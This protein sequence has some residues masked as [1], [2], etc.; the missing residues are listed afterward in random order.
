MSPVELTPSALSISLLPSIRGGPVTIGWVAWVC[1]VIPKKSQDIISS[2]VIGPMQKSIRLPD[3]QSHGSDQRIR[4]QTN[5]TTKPHSPD[6]NFA[7]FRKIPNPERF[8]LIS[9][10]LGN[11]FFGAQFKLANEKWGWVPSCCFVRFCSSTK[12]ISLGVPSLI[13]EMVY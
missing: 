8:V 6:F 9:L 10:G 11:S 13:Q 2:L 4:D 3:C 12:V 1:W 7:G 5:Q